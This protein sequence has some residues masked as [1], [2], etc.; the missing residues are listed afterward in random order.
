M[1][2]REL[3][4]ARGVMQARSARTVAR[5]QSLWRGYGEIVRVA[6]EDGLASTAIVKRV[7]PPSGEANT[8]SDVRKRRSYDV[9]H[10][11]YERYSAR[12]TDACRVA[13]LYG[14]QRDESGWT[15]VLADLDAAFPVR[16]DP[17]R[18]HAL[19]ACLAWL[20]AFHAR[21]MNDA[22]DGLWPQGTYWHLATRLDELAIDPARAHELD[23]ALASA[24]FRTILHGDAKEANFC[25]ARDERAVAAVD[26]QYAGRGCGMKDVAYLLHGHPDA[27]LDAYFRSLRAKL[28]GVD[29]D[30]L[31][32]EWRAL[33]PI[34]QQDF[35]RFLAGWRG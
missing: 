33:F 22:G 10:A 5:I 29:A 31:E 6:F 16:R 8:A 4:W 24:R 18:G 12:C 11:F 17:A 15:F 27:Y 25:F 7:S 19:E 23:R 13:R 21:F 3:E 26:F 35:A 34:A 28:R 14:A 32:R 9:E 20:A 30:A 2:A 1:N